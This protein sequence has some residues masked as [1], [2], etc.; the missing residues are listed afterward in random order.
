MKIALLM[1]QNS[2]SGREYLSSLM[3]A[4]IKVDVIFYGK[5]PVFN[6]L[7]D[8]RC[9]GL[10]NPIKFEKLNTY[11]NCYYFESLNNKETVLF[12]KDNNYILGIQGG[13][14]IL[15]S[16][17]MEC[18]SA[19]I[20]NFHPGDLPSYRGCSAPEWQIIEGKPIISTCHILDKGIDTGPIYSKKKL[21]I[22]IDD[23]H[24][25][26]SQIYPKQAEYLVETLVGIE[27]IQDFIKQLTVQDERFAC[28]RKYIGDDV[29]NKMK[30][31]MSFSI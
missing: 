25:M 5:F 18:F 9:G 28:Y 22:D 6:K 8:K 1:K 11:F 16:E 12:L 30:N 10:W 20:I 3:M 19:G 13:V 23:Y 31:K 2:Y 14:G 4:G 21:D 24:K 15:N 29:I 17:I 7:E 27:I 26:R